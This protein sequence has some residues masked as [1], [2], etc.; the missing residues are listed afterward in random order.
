MKQSI[1]DLINEV[2]RKYNINIIV[3]YDDIYIDPKQ[4]NY[5][6]WSTDRIQKGNNIELISK[7]KIKIF[8]DN[9]SLSR[10]HDYSIMYHMLKFDYAVSVIQN[11]EIQLSSLSYLWDNDPLEYSEFFRRTGMYNLLNNDEIEK[12]KEK[13]FIFCFSDSCR[14]EDAWKLYG[15]NETGIALGFNF[16][17]FSDN[18]VQEELYFLKDITYDFGY[19]FDFIIE[20]QEKLYSKFQRRLVFEGASTFGKFYK[21]G[22]YS[23]ERE[24]RLCFD[25]QSNIDY[26]DIYR[27]FGLTMPK[28]KDLENYFKIEYDKQS[29]RYFIKVPLNNDL[30]DLELTEVICGKNVDS[31]KFS[32]LESLTKNTPIKLWKRI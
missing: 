27:Q 8:L 29:N 3:D 2:L 9:K 15:N 5:I 17:K 32:Q 22:K 7:D 21:R 26:K 6:F 11:K 23:F 28:E 4:T 25:Y 19:D 31:T 1:V 30:F 14:N 13:V 12:I 24:I 18:P 16:T 20:M 10:V